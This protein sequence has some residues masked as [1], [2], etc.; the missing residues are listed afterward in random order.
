MVRT[1]LSV[2][3]GCTLYVRF[4]LLLYVACLAII[5]DRIITS[6]YHEHE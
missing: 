6:Y 4:H 3:C 2:F 5:I 1:V